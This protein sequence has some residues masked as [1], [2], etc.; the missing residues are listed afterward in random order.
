MSKTRLKTTFLKLHPGL[1]ES[2]EHVYSAVV[3]AAAEVSISINIMR[4]Y[5]QAAHLY[6][7]V[8]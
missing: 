1:S 5:C 8:I 7:G 6:W 2:N 4:S 3:H